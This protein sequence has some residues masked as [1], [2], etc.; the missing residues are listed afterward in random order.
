MVPKS[1]EIR[2][3]DA[4]IALTAAEKRA[5]RALLGNYPMLGFAPVAE[6]SNAA[7]TSPATVLRF[8]SRLGFASYPQFQRA[9]RDELEERTKSP[10]QRSHEVPA[11]DPDHFLDRFFDQTIE[12]LRNSVG[13]I[14]LSEFEAACARIAEQRTACHLVGGRFTD[15]IARYMEAHLRLVR[16][17][18]RRLDGRPATR[19]DQLLDIKA[20]DT[21]L[22]FDV[23][24]YDTDL[25]ETAEALAARRAFPILI[26]DEWISPLSRYAKIVLPCRISVERVWDANTV[27]FALAEAII[28]RA[29]ELAWS[30]ASR[31]IGDIEQN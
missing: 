7:G 3:H 13:G 23:R 17:G 6:F 10:L 15:A 2:I 1:V 26:T 9:L 31:R 22:F 8:V 12:N 14:P 18:I 27:L 16:P 30:T 4:M 11:R 5:A 28:A 25:Y 24:R 29:T 20:G 21:V 19:Q